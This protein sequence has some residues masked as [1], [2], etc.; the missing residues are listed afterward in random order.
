MEA[1]FTFCYENER[2]AEAIVKAV[3]PDNIGIPSS[4]KITATKRG[5]EVVTLVSCEMKL[6]TFLATIDDLLRCVLVAEKAFSVAKK[7]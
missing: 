5:R 1:E 4:M 6:E 2:E 7:A 3:S